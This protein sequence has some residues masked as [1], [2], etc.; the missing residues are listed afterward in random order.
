M[1]VNAS[2]KTL[3]TVVALAAIVSIAYGGVAVAQATTADPVWRGMTGSRS[4]QGHM[5]GEVIVKLRSTSSSGASISTEGPS[6]IQR[7]E[8]ETLV[9]L[10]GQYGLGGPNGMTDRRIAKRAGASID[11]RPLHRLT[12]SEDIR[13]V[14]D[15]LSR[16]PAVEYAQPNYC[17]QLHAVPNDPYYELQYAH[18]LTQMPSAWD[19][20][21][22]HR[23]V[24]VAVIGT[25]I[26][27]Y[28]PDLKDNLWVNEDEIPG[29][30]LDDDN[31]GYVDD[32]HGWD[33][34]EDDNDIYPTGDESV[35]FHE[36]A[37]AGVI[38]A[39]G[40][41]D[42]GVCGV[43]WKCSIM[44][45]RLSDYLT[46]AEI[47]AALRYA[48][49]NGA[50]VVNMSFGGTETDALLAEALN[51]A[52][53]QGVLLIASAG[54]DAMDMPMYP[55]AHYNVMS[56]AATDAD[57]LRTYSSFGL[58]VDIDA[59]GTDVATTSTDNSY[60]Y[61]SGTSFS[62]P[63][64]AGVAALILARRP[65]LTA[66][67][68]RAI[69]ENAT[70]PLDYSPLDPNR[71]YLGTGRVNAYRALEQ[72]AVLPALGEIVAPLFGQAIASDNGNLAVVLLAQGIAYRLEI[73]PY[74]GKR[75]MLISEGPIST[76]GLIDLS[77]PQP[78][79]GTYLLRLTVTNDESIHTDTKIF[80]VTT[81]RPQSHWPTQPAGGYLDPEY[82]MSSP[83]CT[84]INGDGHTEVV[85]S[86]SAYGETGGRTNVLLGARTHIWSASGNELGGWPKTIDDLP[87]YSSSAVGD[88]DGDGDYDVVTVT[89]WAGMVYVWDGNDGTL[90]QG[91]WPKTL[92]PGGTYW[93]FSIPCPTL[94]DLDGDGDS[95]ILVAINPMYD[96]NGTLGLYAL[97]GDGTILWQEPYDVCGLVSAADLDRDGDV[98]LT[99]CGYG[100]DAAGQYDYHTYLVDHQ[101]RCLQTWQGGTDKGTVITDLNADGQMEIVFCTG[102]R[103]Q[104]VDPDGTTLWQ[105]EPLEGFG[106]DGAMSAGDLDGDGYGEVY[107]HGYREDRRYPHG[108]VWAWNHQGKPLAEAGFPKNTLGYAFNSAPVIGDIDADGQNELLVGSAGIELAAWE[109]DGT[110]VAAFPRLDLDPEY[111]A[112]CALSD[113]DGDG[114]TEILFGGYDG[115]FHAIDLHAPYDPQAIDWGMFRHDPQCSGWALNAPTLDAVA[116]PNEI[117][118]GQE[119]TLPLI[120]SNP[121]HLPVRV[122]IRN[123]PEGA[124]CDSQTHVFSWTP[125]VTQSGNTHTFVL[126][127]T[128]GV[129]QDSR[130]ISIAVIADQR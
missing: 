31:N 28:H 19:L 118:P 85:Q 72:T 73:Q 55:A 60:T 124:R 75:W 102:D 70:D 66:M 105:T 77:L 89:D 113:L 1:R 4:R 49:A 88:V 111:Y 90:L 25:G 5:P 42:I 17:Y 98:E 115:R 58:W 125:K 7:R 6:Q 3:L 47:A 107:V 38:G 11:R 96:R 33:F 81:S 86:S 13:T 82:F 14:C 79:P 50:H 112:S 54:N 74:E 15:R 95:E 16:D 93:N 56:V 63:Y 117:R 80:T 62:A 84:D 10:Q 71:T 114:D 119:L 76:G 12:T 64:V 2:Q 116:T 27:T 83:I 122:Y 36:T 110:P 24:V 121:D 126:F 41:N 100:P 22:G 120:I 61:T 103:V 128:D 57:E 69:L 9:R 129:R 40:N 94:A 78:E 87:A 44:G 51:E 59:P 8:Q 104:A 123:M 109:A 35:R 67:E 45:L 20:T 29:N 99:F 23:Q 68:V 26:D 101:G 34:D 106:G 92:N 43:N 52:H 32:V 30:G 97:Q 18:E 130:R 127:V 91:D 21:T 37:V 53:E 46:S 48:A 39:A 65:E 108:Q